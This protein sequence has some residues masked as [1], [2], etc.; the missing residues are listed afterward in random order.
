MII[1]IPSGST[2]FVKV[3]FRISHIQRD[4]IPISEI[5][6]GFSHNLLK[7]GSIDLLYG[8]DRLNKLYFK[9]SFGKDR[10]HLLYKKGFRENPVSK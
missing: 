9:G 7:M 2:L 5:S 4:K 1:G 6:T 8:D 10:G 3:L